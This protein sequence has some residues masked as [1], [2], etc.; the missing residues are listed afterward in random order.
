MSA[1]D[2]LIYQKKLLNVQQSKA[3]IKSLISVERAQKLDLLIHLISNLSQPLIVCGPLGIGKSMLLDVLRETKKDAWP[4]CS[5]VASSAMSFESVREQ[6]SRQLMQIEGELAG[7][8]LAACLSYFQQKNQKIVLTIDDAGLLMPGLITSLIEFADA[9][10]SIRL[11]LALTHDELHLK[12]SSDKIIDECHFIEIPPLNRKQCGTFLQN[13]SAQPSAGISFNAVTEV[14]IDNLYSQT[15]GIPGRIIAELPNLSNYQSR[16]GVKWSFVLFSAGLLIA[17]GWLLYA[18]KP[19]PPKNKPLRIESAV[20]KNPVEVN[21]SMPVLDAHKLRPEPESADIVE[22]RAYGQDEVIM[23]AQVKEMAA[24]AVDEQEEPAPSGKVAGIE[25]KISEQTQ[26]SQS[27]SPSASLP[28]SSIPVEKILNEGSPAKAV[29]EKITEPMQPDVPVSFAAPIAD[30]AEQ[31][32]GK[33]WLKEQLPK[34][35]TYQLMVLSQRQS[36]MAVLKKY[37]ALSDGIKIVEVSRQNKRQYILL[38][39][40]YKTT[41]QAE[42]AK[43]FLPAALRQA[44]LRRFSVLQKQVSDN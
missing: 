24:T 15:H 17:M 33:A 32:D 4:I 20:S 7:E 31:S 39:G 35:Y 26:V 2:S 30:V 18:S 27:L 36:A 22:A 25:T 34:N 40:S 10:E 14:L 9:N 13:L 42:Q 29:E 19:T 37:P 23:A 12:T 6:F 11:V 38:Y 3:S 28:E 8:N 21:V 16:N 41:K 43:K 1:S 44:W 5:I